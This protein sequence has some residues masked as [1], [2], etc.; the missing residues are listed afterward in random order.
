MATTVVDELVVKLTL[1]Q[2]QYKRADKEVDKRVTETERKAKKVDA[3]RDKRMKTSALQAKAFA[4]ALKSLA[5]TIGSVLG[6]TGGA[7]GL[8]GAVVALTNF[9][10]N[11]RRATVSTGM[12][13]REMQAWG[14]AARRLGADAQSG[15]QAIAELAREQK[16]FNLTGNAPAMQ[17]LAR[18]GVRV[19]SDVSIADM[20]G[21]AQDAYRNAAPGQRGQ[22]EAGLAAGGLS[23][24][25]IVAIKSEK[26]VREEFA[27][28]F[29]ESASENRKALD[30]VTSALEAVKNSALNIANAIA[31]IAQP[32]VEQFAQWASQGAASLSAFNDRVQAAGG[33]VEGFMKVLD[34]ES[35]Q[36]AE[37]LRALGQGLTFLH[38]AVDVAV[39][40]FKQ[41]YRGAQQLFDWFDQK[42]GALTGQGPG[43]VKGAVESVGD[44]VKWAWKGLV[45]DA[46]VAPGVQLTPDA[47]ARINQGTTGASGQRPAS[48]RP[49]AAA[50]TGGANPT[51]QD[52]MQH[53]VANGLSV[54]QAAAVAASLQGESNLNPAAYNP[55]GGGQGARGL[56]QWRGARTDAFRAATGVNPD[57]ATWQQQLG[58]M[59]NNPYERRL[60]DR[61]LSGPGGAAEMGAG[62]SRVFE[63]HGNVAED[64]RRGQQAQR[65]AQ[66][67][68]AS[69][70][71][72][73][74]GQGPQIA[75]NGPVTV[76]AN[77]PQELVGGI[78]RISNVQN[79][80]SG[81]R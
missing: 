75:I 58:F 69:G 49:T 18:I 53:L 20:L 17:A 9:E 80:N 33:G 68:N 30:S 72:P 52:I 46:R 35:P 71:A 45:G 47:Q 39:Y 34:E 7:A 25:L 78:Q 23:P 31:A 10:T 59:L 2:S 61:S 15:A 63:A 13:N 5:F 57:Q 38:E 27:R 12:S 24:D 48:A 8:V 4:G 54:Q 11:L 28:S 74:A 32:A 6:V 43:K 1:D 51:A 81:V 44:A 36:L 40:G 64:L 42:F 70:T 73:V 29:A 3:A 14:S 79:F 37:L 77:N 41:L 66:Q 62:F 76:Q 21:Q 67:Y 56:A 26:N 55:A 16:Q 60:L 19:G 65:L 50:P 22:I